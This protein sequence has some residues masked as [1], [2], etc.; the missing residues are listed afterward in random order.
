LARA[1]DEIID[2]DRLREMLAGLNRRQ[3]ETFMEVL[4]EAL[5]EVE[6]EGGV[7]SRLLRK[8]RHLHRKLLKM[9]GNDPD[10]DLAIRPAQ[11]PHPRALS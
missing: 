5:P 3:R 11:N 7:D 2:T 10:G 8:I 4:I 9:V 1:P 6:P